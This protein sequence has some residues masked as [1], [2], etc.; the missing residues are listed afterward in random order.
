MPRTVLPPPEEPDLPV[1]RLVAR[2]R[3]LLG[4][5][6]LVRRCCALLGGA[7]REEHLDLMPW[8][9]GHTWAVGDAVRDPAR[10]GEHWVR[11]WGAR[12]LLHS[13]SDVATPD[14][15]AGLDDAHWRPAETCVRVVARHD[16]AGAGPP[17][18]R[19][20]GHDL[21]RVRL[22]AARAL[23]VVG[24]VE[25]ARVLTGLL[26]DPDE[27]VRRAAGRAWPVLAARLDLVGPDGRTGRADPGPVG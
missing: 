26:A 24:D 4:P 25:H 21:P 10:W 15:L 3:E 1:P 5:D 9:T 11:H 8:L 27:G 20:A 22:Q 17:V 23:A 12:G 2:A 16:V 13:W 7:S 18:A 19:L 14:V 6:V